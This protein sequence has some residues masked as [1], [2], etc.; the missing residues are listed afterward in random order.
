MFS[1][2]LIPSAT[3]YPIRSI[4]PH[5]NCLIE[6]MYSLDDTS[7]LHNG[8]AWFKPCLVGL[9][10]MCIVVST[11]IWQLHKH[12]DNKHIKRVVS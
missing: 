1:L 7:S 9:T 12:G 5:T 3:A 8:N 4:H 6:V 11:L 2:H 10:I